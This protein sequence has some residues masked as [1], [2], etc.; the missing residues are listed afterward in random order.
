MQPFRVTLAHQTRQKMQF[1]EAHLEPFGLR[2][3][4]LSIFSLVIFTSL[5]GN[6][7]ISE[8]VWKFL[9]A[10]LPLNYYLV[11]NLAA[12]ELINSLCHAFILVYLEKESW[13]FGEAMCIF[14]EPSSG[15]KHVCDYKFLGHNRL[16]SLQS[17]VQQKKTKSF[18][19]RR[20]YQRNMDHGLGNYAATFITRKLVKISENQLSCSSHF[21]G[22]SSANYNKYSFVRLVFTF[23][24]P[25]FVIPSA[26]IALTIKLKLHVQRIDKEVD[27]KSNVGFSVFIALNGTAKPYGV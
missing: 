14:D 9:V 17:H 8:A 3:F 13:I 18:G 2:T 12:A 16:M 11:A 15:A 19:N 26:Y 24:V 7:I 23:A 5:V 4:R 27:D 1:I 22:D 10:S 21:P 20:H 6:L 25:Y